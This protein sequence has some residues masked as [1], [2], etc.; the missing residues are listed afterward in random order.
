MPPIPA[1]SL[2][3]TSV[4]LQFWAG[5]SFHIQEVPTM[6][7]EGQ[8]WRTGE[9]M[10][11][12]WGLPGLEEAILVILIKHLLKDPEFCLVATNHLS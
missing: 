8:R 11:E 4:I 5:C 3:K 1:L 6:F 10:K 2:W 7:S 12:N 9:G